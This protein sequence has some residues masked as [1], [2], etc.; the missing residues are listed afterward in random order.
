MKKVIIIFSVLL[1]IS[2]AVDDQNK[3]IKTVKETISSGDTKT[4]NI[5][6]STDDP[7]EIDFKVDKV[8][9]K[10]YSLIV[11]IDLDNGAYFISPH[12]KGNYKGIF[13][14]SVEDNNKIILTDTI[15]ETPQSVEKKDPWSGEPAYVVD[16]NT[17]YKQNFTLTSDQNFEVT[18]RVQFTIEP[19]CTYEQIGF[20]ISYHSGKVSVKHSKIIDC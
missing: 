19:K 1:C 8:N 10:E 17:I 2:C 6:K 18:G 7:Y 20:V 5:P 4:F 12:S 13:V 11:S 16:V 15:I 9:A 14:I 3:E